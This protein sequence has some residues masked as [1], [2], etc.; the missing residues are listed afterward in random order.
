MRQSIEWSEW[1][2]IISFALILGSFFLVSQINAR[3][4]TP[5]ISLPTP[6]PLAPLAIT[7]TGAVCRPGTYAA[8]P[9]TPLSEILR[10]AHPK[11]HANLAPYSSAEL[12]FA[13]QVFHIEELSEIVV[14]VAGAVLEEVQITLP[15]GSR[16]S[17]LKGKI[18]LSAE[19]DP[20]FLKRKKQLRHREKVV[21]PKKGVAKKCTPSV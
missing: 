7:L 17:D 3:R 19:A 14:T 16:I 12:L 4:S 9:G 13:D 10:K 6:Q 8:E 21:V 5:S 15:A 18:S 20:R 2:L 11:L 1:T